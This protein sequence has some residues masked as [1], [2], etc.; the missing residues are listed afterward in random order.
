[1]LSN[2]LIF[3]NP[4]ILNHISSTQVIPNPVIPNPSRT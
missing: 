3:S 2:P 4:L 1:M